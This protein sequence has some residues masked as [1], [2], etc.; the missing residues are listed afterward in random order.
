MVDDVH[1]MVTIAIPT[2]NRADSYLKYALEGAANQTYGNLEIIVADNCSTDNTEEVV[3]AFAAPRLRYF[4]HVENMQA[5]DNFNFCVEQAKGEYFLLLHDDDVID[6]D[7][8][9]VCMR[10]ASYRTDIGIIRTGTRTIDSNGT[11]L[12]EKFNR[13]AGLSTADFFLGWFRGKTALYLC[14]TLFNTRR[15]REIGGFNSKHQLFQDCMAEVQLAARFGR[16]DVRDVKAGFRKHAGARTVAQKVGAWCEDSLM[17]LEVMCD[18]VPQDEAPLVEREGL[19][20]FTEVNYGFASG[21]RSP[22]ERLATYWMVY[23]K[24]D[25][26]Y[27]PFDFFVY[28]RIRLQIRR[29]ARIARR[30]LVRVR[31]RRVGQV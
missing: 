11:V 23:R 10:A 15:L 21:I 1:P 5:N 18:L 25:R 22:I 14:S 3:R 17:L 4:K 27:S 20:F 6:E 12:K 9:E 28:R 29:L 26:R 31:M 30:V 13:V 16:V 24:F 2:Y 7:F 19:R 8:V